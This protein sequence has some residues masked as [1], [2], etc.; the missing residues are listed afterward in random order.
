M[1]IAEAITR[2]VTYIVDCKI[3]GEEP[4]YG[5]HSYYGAA[6]GRRLQQDLA[7]AI[8]EAMK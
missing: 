3:K 1:E 8:E 2:L 7:E 5:G 4:D 6:E